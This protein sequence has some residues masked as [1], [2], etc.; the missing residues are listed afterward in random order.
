MNHVRTPQNRQKSHAAEKLTAHRQRLLIAIRSTFRSESG[1]RILHWLRSAAPIDGPLEHG[2]ERTEPWPDSLLDDIRCTFLP[3]H[4][5]TVLAWLLHIGGADRP[6][7][8]LPAA[9][10]SID[11]LAALVREGRRRLPSFFRIVCHGGIP[12]PHHLSPSAPG[13]DGIRQ[14]HL[15]ILDAI[16]TANAELSGWDSPAPSS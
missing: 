6:I 8:Q 5:P 10:G 11:P 2:D 1:L 9:G 3:G 4:G 16:A 13:L 7:Y 12:G 14:I 15:E